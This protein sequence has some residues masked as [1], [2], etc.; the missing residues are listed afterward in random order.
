MRVLN[1]LPIS[2]LI[3]SLILA[4]SGSIIFC[5]SPELV[6]VTSHAYAQEVITL[7]LGVPAQGMFSNSGDARYYQVQVSAGQHLV[8]ALDAA[9]IS[10]SCQNELYVRYGQLPSRTEYDDKYDLDRNPDQSV[11]IANTQSGY[12]YILAYSGYAYTPYSYTI[13]SNIGIAQPVPT[14]TSAT[15]AAPPPA[16]REHFHWFGCTA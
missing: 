9:G 3:L 5:S 8:V 14:P 2:I 10:A 11:D 15:G 12:Y 16:C 4:F 1:R 13:A 7:S 6:G